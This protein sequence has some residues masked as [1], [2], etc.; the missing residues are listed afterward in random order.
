[1]RGIVRSFA[2]IFPL[3]IAEGWG[4]ISNE[5]IVSTTVKAAA[6]RELGDFQNQRI[7]VV[8]DGTP[9][10]GMI[11]SALADALRNKSAEVMLASQPDST[12][13]N[14]AFKI[15]NFE[16]KYKKGSRRGFLRQHRIKR[17]FQSQLQLTLE[18]G[19]SGDIIAAYNLPLSYNDQIDPG[20]SA[21]V[22]SDDIP[23]LALKSPG[24]AISKLAK[25]ALVVASVTVLVYLFFANK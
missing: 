1:M 15:L 13:E 7:V 8:T 19:V 11:A 21:S 9:L 20:S 24:G 3:L 5:Q 18:S 6:L 25:P 17:E 23:E 22:K 4:Q 14:L 2:L 10:N 12:S 16:F